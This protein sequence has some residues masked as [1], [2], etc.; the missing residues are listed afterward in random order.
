MKSAIT[1]RV[2]ALVSTIGFGCGDCGGSEAVPPQPAQVAA[3]LQPNAPAAPAPEAP[4]TT[5]SSQN[6][7]PK[8]GWSAVTL[9][10]GVP[11]CLFASGQAHFDAKSIDQVGPQELRAGARVTIGAF[12]GWCVNETCDQRPSLQC[13]VDREGPTLVVRSKYWGYRKDGA[14]CDD[15]PCRPVGAGCVTPELEA[16]DYTVVHGERS[17]EV[18]IPSVLDKPCFGTDQRTPPGT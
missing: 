15:G 2:L 18:R 1:A 16:G 9:E 10:N 11:L 7:W 17:F 13:S 4:A 14:T 12:A 5:E 3:P 6:T 8:P